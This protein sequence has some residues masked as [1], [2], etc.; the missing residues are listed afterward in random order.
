MYSFVPIGRVVMLIA[1][2]S[3]KKCNQS[4]LNVTGW[5]SIK[6]LKITFITAK[7]LPCKV[8][9]DCSTEIFLVVAGKGVLSVSVPTVV[10]VLHVTVV[11][12]HDA[13]LCMIINNRVKLQS[14]PASLLNDLVVFPSAPSPT[15][16]Q[17]KTVPGG[18]GENKWGEKMKGK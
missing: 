10:V 17:L 7:P 12:S 18:S 9:S 6:S 15:P 5:S 8:F 16:S 13:E 11:Q 1:N 3:S 4:T 2:I 14:P